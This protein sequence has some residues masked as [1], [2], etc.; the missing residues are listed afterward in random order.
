[1]SRNAPAVLRSASAAAADE[2]GRDLIAI[3][4]RWRGRPMGLRGA[5]CNRKGP[6]V[7][8]YPS[9]VGTAIHAP[10]IPIPAF[11][12]ALDAGSCAFRR[13][14]VL[15]R[16]GCRVPLPVAGAPLSK[17]EVC[18]RIQCDFPSFAPSLHPNLWFLCRPSSLSEVA[19]CRMRALLAGKNGHFLRPRLALP[20]VSN[21]LN[22]IMPPC[23]CR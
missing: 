2:C 15:V 6:W 11:S 23:G 22:S 16:A 21:R 17:P 13:V 4:P 9:E 1:M 14:F 19:F 7:V 3:I 10:A 20:S 8:F 5:V 12:D 18:R